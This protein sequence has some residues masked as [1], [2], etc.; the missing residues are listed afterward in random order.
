MRDCFSMSCSNGKETRWVDD[1]TEDGYTI[2]TPENCHICEGTGEVEDYCYCCAHE[3]S[4]CCCGAWDDI[5]E[6][7]YE[8][9][10]DDE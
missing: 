6:E 5:E 7:W 4:E 9:E 3:P 10:V 8:C 1:G 2:T